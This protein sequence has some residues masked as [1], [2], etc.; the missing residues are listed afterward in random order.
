MVEIP[1]FDDKET[2]KDQ[3]AKEK[4]AEK[5]IP[6]KMED[7]LNRIDKWEKLSSN[8]NNLRKKLWPEAMPH[9]DN[10]KKELSD[11]NKK[12]EKWIENNSKIRP[13]NKE[14]LFSFLDGKKTEAEK[15]LAA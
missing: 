13:E 1:H 12:F 11:S 10:T 5:L 2:L 8:I 6:K 4:W 15:Q 9:L 14:R 7:N 3:N